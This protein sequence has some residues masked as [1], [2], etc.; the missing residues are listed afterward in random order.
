MLECVGGVIGGMGNMLLN[1]V[2]AACQ[3][4]TG[5]VSE[6]EEGYLVLVLQGCV[7]VCVRGGGV[8]GRRGREEEKWQ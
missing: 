2:R 3:R 1:A 6:S 5:C 7:R 8:G 4:S